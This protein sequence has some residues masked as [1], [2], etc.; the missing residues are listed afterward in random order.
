MPFPGIKR[1]TH[2]MNKIMGFFLAVLI[3]AGCITPQTK[4]VK[5]IEQTQ[6]NSGISDKSAFIPVDR[7]IRAVN[8]QLENQPIEI[9]IQGNQKL[10]YTS[11]K[12]S[13]PFGIAIYF[14]ETGIAEDFKVIVPENN[15]IGDVMVTYVDKEMTTTKV[16]ILL[17]QDFNYEVIEN[18]HVLRVTLFNGMGKNQAIA[19]KVPDSPVVVADKNSPQGL[20]SEETIIIPDSTAT[21][22][23]IEFNTM[24]D[25]KTGI[26]VQTSHPVKYDITRGDANNKLFL[27]LYN[28]IIPEYHK[29]PLLTQYFKSA[30]EGLMPIQVPGV[31]KNSK[32]EIKIRD[33]VP[34]RV[35][36]TQNNISLFFEASAIDPPLFNKAK[37]KISQGPQTKTIEAGRQKIDLADVPPLIAD[38]KQTME[39]AIFGSQKKYTGERIKLDFYETD[40]K[41]VFRILRSVGKLNF[42]IDKDVQGKVTLTL[43]DP[44]PWDQVLD[45]V[46]RMNNLGMKKE[47]NVI[48]IA[49]LET[50]SKEEKMMQETIVARQK[51]LEQ[52]KSL[53]LLVIEYIPI[54]YSDAESDIKPHIDQILTK[55]RG[56]I[57]V[58]KRT[59]M[60]VITDTQGKIDQ[61]R[62]IIYRLDKVTP[63]IMIEAKVVEVSKNFSRKLGL[64]IS[65][66]KTQT[67]HTG[68]NEDFA[69]ALNTP[70]SFD[71]GRGSGA[72]NFY[73]ILGS[74]FLNLNAQ[75]EASEVKGDSKIISSPRI[76]T[77]DNETATIKQGEEVAY[78]E[79]DDAGGSSVKFK[80]A[81]LLLDVTPHVTPDKRISMKIHLTKNSVKPNTSPPTINTNEVNTELLVNNN[82]TIVIGGIVTTTDGKDNFGLPFLSDIPILGRL[83]RTDTDT[84]NRSELLIFITPSIIQLEQRS[85]TLTTD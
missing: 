60:I 9:K 72:F 63:Q 39:E 41:N 37:K 79:R 56:N 10:V 18:D 8:V 67:A 11:I 16:E 12:Q 21:M 76:L 73:K 81:D 46:L 65:L 26:V 34:Y 75:I 2:R 48:R 23:H 31:K 78:L 3:V 71:S 40:I 51:S 1:K 17:K 6:T 28:T 15:S 57:T 69:I 25:G 77:L 7:Q 83:F 68:R 54:N 20:V 42:A 22:T 55:D 45:L 82:D 59:N 43:E 62:E 24:K 74:N 13:F 70:V 47:G 84:D 4:T 35:V 53:E 66:E 33:Q 27:N 49:T 29:R 58:D 5:N 64:G 80:N 85:N 44:V 61:A 14:P 30:V 19:N 32:I 50:L 52:K 36:Q 38:K